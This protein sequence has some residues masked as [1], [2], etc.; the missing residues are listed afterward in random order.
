MHIPLLFHASLVLGKYLDL[1][2]TLYYM[3]LV[4]IIPYHL[5][6]ILIHLHLFASLHVI[7]TR[8][9]NAHRLIINSIRDS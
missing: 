8:H 5:L 4:H 7:F 6:M 9:R 3:L 1:L 2:M